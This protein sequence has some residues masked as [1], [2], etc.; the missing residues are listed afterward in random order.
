M[1]VYSMVVDHYT[2]KWRPMV[3]PYQPQPSVVIPPVVVQPLISE[4]ELA[5]FRRLLERAR[6]YDRRMNQPDCELESKKQILRDLADKLG[7]KV[8]FL[9]DAPA[10]V[11]GTYTLP[12]P[13]GATFVS[14]NLAYCGATGSSEGYC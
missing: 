7:V 10:A 1:C 13:Q 8:D 3:P 14:D 5:E 6:E 2:D 12:A 4:E 9:D 11:S